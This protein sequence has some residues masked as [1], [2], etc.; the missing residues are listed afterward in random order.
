MLITIIIHKK[1][2]KLSLQ[3]S[4]I[5][6]ISIPHFWS[7]LHQFFI[8]VQNSFCLVLHGPCSSTVLMRHCLNLQEPWL[9]IPCSTMAFWDFFRFKHPRANLTSPIIFLNL[10]LH[11]FWRITSRN[12]TN[13]YCLHSRCKIRNSYFLKLWYAFWSAFNVDQ[14]DT[15]GLW[16][17]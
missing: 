16:N 2:N 5:S 4:K 9:F 6:R 11:L 8:K 13:H 7:K 17:D 14:H 1:S 3:F 10:L 12:A 15:L